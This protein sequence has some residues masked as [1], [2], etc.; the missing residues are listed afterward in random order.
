MYELTEEEWIEQP[1][2]YVMISLSGA[3]D[4]EANSITGTVLDF[5]CSTF[6]VY[7]GG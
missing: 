7:R 3:L 1:G 6:S 5:G 2:G 4:P